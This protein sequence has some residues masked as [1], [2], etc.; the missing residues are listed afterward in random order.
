MANYTLQ[1]ITELR[2]L[3]GM[4]LS[5]IKK[6]LEEAEGDR[7]KA[8][9]ALRKRGASIMEKKSER[10]AGEGLIEAYV[11]GG[12]TGVLVEI[13]CETDFVSRGEL[14]KEFAHDIA[15]QIAS[16][17]PENVEELLAQTYIKDSKLTIADYL[18]DTTGKLGEKI[19]I[20]RFIRYGLG[21]TAEAAA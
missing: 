15:L 8:L 9:E 12:R 6:A 3:T 21:E 19:V 4:G 16:M 2:E 13:N 14:F 11:H 7:S 20:T 18:R 17:A 10:T 5:D 1:D